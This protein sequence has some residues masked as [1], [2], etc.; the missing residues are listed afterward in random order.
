[1]QAK[2][3]SKKTKLTHEAFWLQGEAIHPGEEREIQVPI[4]KLP[5]G[6]AIHI[7]VVVS[8]A[9][10]PG[11]VVLL[12]AGLHGDEINGVEILRRFLRSGYNKPKRG[13]TL[14]IPLL[15]IFGFINY[16]REAIPGKDVNRSF[17]GN[18]NGSLASRLAAYITQ[19]I[20]PWIDF[21][22]DFHT[23]G[24]SRYNFPQ[25]RAVLK[26]KN[27]LTLAS[28]FAAPFTIDAPFRPGSLRQTAAKMGK[29]IIV[30]EGGESLRFDQLAISEGL[31]GLMRLL[32]AFNMHDSLTEQTKTQHTI[33][34]M[35]WVRA[36]QAGLFQ[37]FVEPG[38]P[39]EKGQTLGIVTDTLGSSRQMVQ[40]T[41]SGFIIAVNNAPVVNHGDALVNIG[42]QF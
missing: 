35:S 2:Q 6:T 27:N 12:M 14:T 13:S 17:P 7:P 34:K 32:A 28:H 26:D 37:P 19:E 24:G 9:F 10:E 25:I 16:N 8:R 33:N 18:R 22:V 39:I 30:Y 42:F 5:S 11:P 21:G 40:A 20:L 31:E 4:A 41:K 1:M 3:K 15:N 23:G 36:R 29:H 38:V